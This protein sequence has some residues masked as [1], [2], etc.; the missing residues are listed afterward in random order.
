MVRNSEADA[1]IETGVETNNGRIRTTDWEVEAY[2]DDGEHAMSWMVRRLDDTTV[3]VQPVVCEAGLRDTHGPIDVYDIDE[4]T[5]TV[6]FAQELADADPIEAVEIARGYWETNDGT[7]EPLAN[8]HA[9]D[10]KIVEEV[11]A[12]DDVDLDPSIIHA[13]L[14]EIEEWYHDDGLDELRYNDEQDTGPESQQEIIEENDERIVALIG[15]GT[16]GNWRE[17][18]EDLF[19]ADPNRLA[20]AIQYC[21]DRQAREHEWSAFGSKQEANDAVG[22]SDAL[23]INP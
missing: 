3:E 20:S 12:R 4:S 16:W 9:I 18:L 23:V 14:G 7:T 19:D 5:G 1:E 10:Q 21:H 8:D 11:A 22:Y 6:E 13:A 15:D 2:A 17:T